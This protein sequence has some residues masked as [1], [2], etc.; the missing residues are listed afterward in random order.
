MNDN[1]PNIIIGKVGALLRQP[2]TP[3]NLKELD[4]LRFEL[5]ETK[6]DLM[7]TLY[8]QRSRMLMPKDKNLSELD[9]KVSMNASTA[10]M[11]RDYTFLCDLDRIIE[12]RLQL[13]QKL[14]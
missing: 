10:V 5:L 2:M 9:R 13:A 1:T 7:Q 8:E 4:A 3:D 14:L 6:N 12:Q 11:E